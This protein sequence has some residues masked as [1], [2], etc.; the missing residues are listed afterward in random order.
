MLLVDYL[1]KFLVCEL[2]VV[3][4]VLPLLAQS[5]ERQEAAATLSV[6][7]K[8]VTLPVTVRDKHGQ[9]VRNLTKDDFVLQ[10]DGRPTTIKY[11]SQEANLP[12]T[13]GLLVD[14]SLSQR[15]VLDEERNASRGFLDQMLAQEKDKAF[16]VHFDHE[17]ELLQDLT[18]SRDLLQKA[19]DALQTPPPDRERSGDDG[20]SSPNGQRR[21][22]RAGGTL[23]YDAV[24]LA[25]DELMKKQQGRKAVIILSDGVDRG[26]KKSLESA[27]E[28]AQRA[29]T[30]VYSILF[31]DSQPERAGYEHQRRGGMGGGWPGGGGGYPGGGGGWPGGGG[32]RGGGPRPQQEARTDGKKIL[33]RISKETGGRLFEVSKKESVGQIYTSIAEELR[34]QYSLGYTPNKQESAE[35]YHKITLTAKGKDLSVQTRD[36]YY[37]DR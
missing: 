25:S 31:K 15:N 14:T 7:V 9:I 37:A 10:E 8:V 6:D 35:G 26:S 21:M 23:L 22:H 24:F 30:V 28:A 18:S 17:V 16:I 32:R 34:T 20:D 1:R 3:L 13:L 29:D 12:L 2:V 27:I 4:A 19:L 36:G 33:E 11:F 5:S